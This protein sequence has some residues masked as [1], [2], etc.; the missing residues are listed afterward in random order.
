VG[1]VLEG[2]MAGF[3]IF[4]GKGFHMTFENGYTASVQFGP[5]N[6]CEHHNNGSTYDAPRK[7]DTWE[8]MDAEIAAW[9]E[10]G[11]WTLPDQVDGYKS[12][13]DVLRFLNW[14]AGGCK[15]DYPLGG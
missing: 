8:S 4:S 1:F 15:E 10:E 3:G 14:V 11:V 6:Y 2:I 5:G 9:N 13:A 7:T 12:P